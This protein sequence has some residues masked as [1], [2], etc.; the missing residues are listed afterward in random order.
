MGRTIKTPANMGCS[1]LGL[2]LDSR[3]DFA[4]S[5]RFHSDEIVAHFP[6]LPHPQR[7]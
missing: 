6:L 5:V 2:L 7:L 3:Y 4:R 1:L